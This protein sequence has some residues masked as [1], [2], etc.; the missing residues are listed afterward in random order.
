MIGPSGGAIALALD[1]EGIEWWSEGVGQE[2][3][4]PLPITRLTRCVNR[5]GGLMKVCTYVWAA[6]TGYSSLASLD[7]TYQ[8]YSKEYI[9]VIGILVPPSSILAKITIRLPAFTITIAHSPSLGCSPPPPNCSFGTTLHGF[10][11]RSPTYC[12]L[13]PSYKWLV[14]LLPEKGFRFFFSWF[15]SAHSP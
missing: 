3:G 1:E 11:R 14:A 12:G 15:F 7:S 13:Q 10:W 4:N 2:S 6:P 5:S 8:E 9:S